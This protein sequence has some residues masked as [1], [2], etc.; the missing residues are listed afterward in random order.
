MLFSRRPR[1]HGQ[2]NEALLDDIDRAKRSWDRAVETQTAVVDE[3]NGR[4][5]S[6]Q[7]ALARQKYML[8]FREARER[9]VRGRLQASVID[10]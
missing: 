8:L 3:G 5:L 1:L 9:K 7:T 6:A 10:N 2:Y 4:E